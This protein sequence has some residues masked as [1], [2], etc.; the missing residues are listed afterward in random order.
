MNLCFELGP[1]E[2]NGLPWD[3]EK[4]RTNLEDLRTFE[5]ALDQEKNA[6][7][8]DGI[9]VGD[10]FVKLFRTYY[11][12]GFCRIKLR[13]N[14]MIFAVDGVRAPLVLRRHDDHS[15]LYRVIS[16]CY[17]WA[18]LELDYWN[19]GTHKGIWSSRPHDLGQVQTR[20]IEIC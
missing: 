8:D 9:A 11:S 15:S 7:R 1:N 17:L 3:R 19:P 4:H 20:M 13:P 2:T 10:G 18:A 14:D 5:E 12:A 6:S 16:E